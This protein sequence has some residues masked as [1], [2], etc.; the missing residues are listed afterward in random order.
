MGK[1]KKNKVKTNGG[2][3]AAGTAAPASAPEA[4]LRTRAA[5]AAPVVRSARPTLMSTLD[6]DGSPYQV[7]VVLSLLLA[8]PTAVAIL[9]KFALLPF[10]FPSW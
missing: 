5:A 1:K 9:V 6:D 4:V 7:L 2:G 10:L 3:P 8:V